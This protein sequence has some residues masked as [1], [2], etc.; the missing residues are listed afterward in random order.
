MGH[1]AHQ[2]TPSINVA[3]LCA[4][5][6]TDTIEHFVASGRGTVHTFT[7]THQNLLPPFNEHLPYVLAYVE[8][9]EGPRVLT[10]IVGCDPDDVRIGQAVVADYATSDRDDGE[11][12]AVPRFRPA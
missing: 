8:L 5:C 7:V 6:L 9:D 12:F 4:Q 11:A 3:P 10:N 1:L 2:S